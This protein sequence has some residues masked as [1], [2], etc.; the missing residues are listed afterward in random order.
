MVK[1][2]KNLLWSV[3]L[4]FSHLLIIY[5]ILAAV[6]TQIVIRGN[7]YIARAM[8]MVLAGEQVQLNTLLLPLLGMIVLGTAVAYGKSISGNYYSALVQRNLRGSLAEH[9]LDMPFCYFDEKGSGSIMTKLSSDIGEVGT[10]ISE[11]LPEILVN[12]ITIISVT[13]YLVQMDGMLIVI[14]FASYPVMLVVA[15]KLSKKLAEIAKRYRSKMDERTQ[16]A[17]DAIQGITVGRSYNLYHVIKRRIDVAIDAIADNGC[18]S[19]RISSMAWVLKG[20][21]TTIPVVV[22]YLFA[23]HETIINRITVGDMLAFTVLLGR[24]IY[25]IGDVVF[26]V[27]EIRTTG[28]AC[29]RLQEIYEVVGEDGQENKTEAGRK[30]IENEKAAQ[31]YA[32]KQ[33]DAPAIS[34][35]NIHFSYQAER[36]IL[37]GVSFEIKQGE[38]VAFAGGSGEGKSTIFRI[39]MGFYPRTAGEF[40]LF[41]KEYAQWSIK[42]LRKN[43]SYVSQNV[44]L[45]PQSIMQNVACGKE[46]A[47]KEDVIEACKAAN[48]HDFIMKLP[49]GYDTVVGERGA[50]LSG[51]ERQRISIARAYLKDAPILL[52]DEPT[53]AVDAGTE[54]EIQEALANIAEGRTVV[55]I[56][57]RLSTIKQ[58]DRIYIVN[59]GQIAEMGTHEELLALK[60]IYAGMYGKEVAADETVA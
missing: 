38:S 57:H 15:D 23:L 13:T 48:I 53:A 31:T 51:G 20:V 34:W 24:I 17:Y 58:S 39:L 30:S 54:S 52:L 25:P 29:K 59:D 14:L 8:D 19:T 40:Y 28:V 55:V 21:L 6:L 4:R 47:T 11:I 16:I 18:K 3:G 10:F 9:L 46:D 5:M 42:E 33:L 35:N 32:P 44:F 37:K 43:F 50:R 7:D 60:G 26:C 1:K 56:A 45:L 2:R 27:N 12:L 22:C 49:N 41:G 36:E